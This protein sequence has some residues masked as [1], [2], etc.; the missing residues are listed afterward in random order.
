MPT[1]AAYIGYRDPAVEGQLPLE[2]SV[3]LICKRRHRKRRARLI[4]RESDAR[5]KALSAADWLIESGR[6][7]VRKSD[8]RIRI[9][10]V[11]RGDHIGATGA[12]RA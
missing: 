7:R 10:S 2:A 8:C 9:N 3:K 4:E 11:D 1:T 12:G 5:Q 6:K